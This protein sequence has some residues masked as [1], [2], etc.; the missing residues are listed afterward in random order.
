MGIQPNTKFPRKLIVKMFSDNQRVQ[1]LDHH[2][3]SAWR[4]YFRMKEKD[5][6]EMI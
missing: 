6:R 5:L 2:E 4:A 1:S 3:R